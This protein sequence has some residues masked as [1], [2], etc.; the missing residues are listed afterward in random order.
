MN[1]ATILCCILF[2]LNTAFANAQ[3][4]KWVQGGGSTEDFTSG[5]E[6]DQEQTK[7]MCTDANGNI[8]ALSQVGNYTIIADTFHRSTAYGADENIML[9]S[10]NCNGQLRWAKLIASS[11]GY[12][13][14]LGIAADSLGHIDMSGTFTND[15]L[16]IGYD[17][18]IGLIY[19]MCGVIQFDT[20]GHFKWIRYIGNNT[21]AT[22]IATGTASAYLITDGSNNI[23]FFPFIKSGA[24]L[25]PGDTSQ[26]GTYEIVYSSTGTLLSATQLF[27]SLWEINSA[28]IDPAT[29][30]LYVCGGINQ[31]AYG[32]TPILDSQ[33][34]AAFDAG[35]S[36]LW[37]YFAGHG[38]DD[39]LGSITLDQTKHLHFCGDAQSPTLTITRFSFNGDSVSNTEYPPYEMSIIMTTDTN[40]HP[41]W[42]KKFV[43]NTAINTLYSITQLPNGKIA[44]AGTFARVVTDGADSLETLPGYGWS[45]FLVVV[46]STGDLQTMQQAYGDGF[47]NEGRV[48]TSDKVGNIYMGGYVSDSIWAGSPPIP[49]YYSIG[50]NSDFFVM[51]YGVDCSCMA[52]PAAA[53]TDTGTRTIGTTYT[54]TT[55]GMDSIVW[56]FGDGYTS[57]GT[58]ALHTYTVAGTF[59]L[60][61]TVY[62]GCGQDSDCVDIVIPC[63]APPV[64]LFTDTGMLT[65][66]AV[67]TGTT[68][69]LDSVVWNFGDGTRDTGNTAHHT[70]TAIGT[71]HICAIAYNPCGNDTACRYDTVLCVTPPTA[72]FTDTGTHTIGTTYTGT[73]TA[74]DSI[75][76]SFGDGHTATGTTALHT[77]SAPGT[78]H[79]CVTAYSPCGNDS[80]CRYDTVLCVTPPTASF[81]DTGINTIGITYTGT[82]YLLDSVVW[83]FGDGSTDTGIT[84][85]HT[86]TAT[87]IFHVCATVYTTCGSNTVCRNDTVVCITTPLASFTDT[88]THKV[89]F[90]YTGGTYLLDSVVWTFGDGHSDTGIRAL[91]TY[92]VT[93]TYHV[94]A[95][96]YTNCGI[97]SSCSNI[98]VTVPTGLMTLPVTSLKVFPNPSNDEL[99]ITGITTNTHYRM[100]DVTG[101]CLQQGD[102][103][104]GNNILPMQQFVPG[105]YILEMTGTDGQRDMVRVVKE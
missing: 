100:L 73:T 46:D 103:L 81:M 17:T 14:P 69:A 90:V 47:Y 11:G 37:K 26:Y 89:G 24:V 68:T 58:T 40:G 84:A 38:D 75:V 28:V 95:T 15:I 91:H 30:K 70:Y 85:L 76:W 41:L 9:T 13:I 12:C 42:I 87:G 1:K 22:E 23:H 8:Y 7:F 60:C 45:P 62:T 35:R 80:A 25:M 57:H 36:L 48:I 32:P 79:V 50:G 20:S 3:Q 88:G 5:T 93:G 63:V 66:G 43:A 74:I 92:S 104:P 82:T 2:F 18:T 94:C 98:T 31:Y 83:N 65:I 39:G 52:M 86:Y 53:F 97:D 105:I 102:L 33:Y 96:V 71:Y 16:H 56:K 77:Y 72:S 6:F 27:D 51:K 99:Y 10:Y 59:Q 54:G 64:A 34:A 29:N 4:F 19:N 49:A 101:I 78:Y 61:G 44:A 55:T 21:V 67:Y